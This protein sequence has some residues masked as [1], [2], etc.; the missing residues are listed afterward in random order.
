MVVSFCPQI[1]NDTYMYMVI[2][3]LLWPFAVLGLYY[4]FLHVPSLLRHSIWHRGSWW[5]VGD[6]PQGTS[7]ICAKSQLEKL[8][9]SFYWRGAVWIVEI[10][11]NN[12]VPLLLLRHHGGFVSVHRNRIT[13]AAA[14]VGVCQSLCRV[15]LKQGPSDHQRRAAQTDR[16]G[17]P[18]KH[19][20]V[21]FI[22]HVRL[23]V[24]FSRSER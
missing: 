5:R 8:P 2:S 17:M 19:F 22:V 7:W 13:T 4:I 16:E 3:L 10:I 1:C 12:L 18:R 6:C 9:S 23:F 15:R 14:A 20:S 11:P 21:G 24:L